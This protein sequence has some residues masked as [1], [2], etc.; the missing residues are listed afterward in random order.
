MLFNGTTRGLIPRALIALVT[1]RL[2]PGTLDKGSGAV[3]EKPW[4]SF[5]D[6][7]PPRVKLPNPKFAA[8]NC[9]VPPGPK[10]VDVPA[11]EP[12]SPNKK[13]S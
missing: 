10:S 2:N 6:R 4:K 11:P 5:L 9:P 7:K 13:L 3:I 12:K 8:K 1:P